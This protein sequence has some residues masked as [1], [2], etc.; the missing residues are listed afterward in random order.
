MLH[1]LMNAIHVTF[2]VVHA[3]SIL[4]M[5]LVGLSWHNFSCSDRA[6]LDMRGLF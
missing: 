3:M 2:K 6:T 4:P 1:V 5:F